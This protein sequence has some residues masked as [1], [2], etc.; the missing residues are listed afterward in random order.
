M[1]DK[2]PGG[3]NTNTTNWKGSRMKKDTKVII[4][5][6]KAPNGND[7]TYRTLAPLDF[8]VAD[9]CKM[10]NISMM[11]IL[12]ATITAPMTAAD[13]LA[14]MEKDMLNEL[15][16]PNRMLVEATIGMHEIAA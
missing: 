11:T 8:T 16:D 1:K 2:K 12:S 3:A 4:M 10:R 9:A 7:R 14:Y 6:A 13:A 5:K 15:F